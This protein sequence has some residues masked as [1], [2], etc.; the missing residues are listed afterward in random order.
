[1][2]TFA[3]D[4]TLSPQLS[5]TSVGGDDSI[6][7]GKSGDN[8]IVGVGEAG[9]T[10]ELFGPIRVRIQSVVKQRMLMDFAAD[11]GESEQLGE[12]TKQ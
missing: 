5:I 1:M 10:V 2:L 3:V 9:A 6:V 8:Q 4:T 11:S 12:V 7:S